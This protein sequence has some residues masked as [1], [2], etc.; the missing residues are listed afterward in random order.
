MN[1]TETGSNGQVT[2]PVTTEQPTAGRQSRGTIK[3][4]GIKWSPKLGLLENL[5]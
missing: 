5:R 2:E 4:L 1:K 3:V